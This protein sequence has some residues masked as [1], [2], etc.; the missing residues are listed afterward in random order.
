M[1]KAR[2]P[3]RGSMQFW[4]RKRARHLL[5]RVR[6]WATK[7]DTKPLGFIGYKAGMTHLH[8]NDNRAKSTTAGEKIF[9]P[10][11]I[12][13]CP[14]ITVAGA[15]FYKQTADGWKKVSHVLAEKQDKYLSRLVSIPKSQKK[16]ID[17][18]TEFDDV[19]LIIHSNPSKTSI[20]TKKPRLIEV[21]MG[22][23]KDEKFAYAKENLGK[24][25][26]IADVF[27]QGNY[28]DV[29]GISKGKGFQG[30]VK[31]YGVPIRQHKSE[32]VKRGIGNLGAWTPKRVD[33][34]VPQAGKMGYHLRTEYNKQ[35]IKIGQDGKDVNRVG[36]ITKYGEI[37]TSYLLVKGS[38][39]G[40]RKRAVL[41]TQAI[42]QDPKAVK[43]APEVV[44]IAR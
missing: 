37:K 8:I 25:V 4:P 11:T 1:S 13:E 28:V 31:R 29:H 30:T 33:Y 44:Y 10:A 21:A 5:A 3:R 41:L 18:I 6:S 35:V 39:I 23:S 17:E 26:A 36:G 20:G 15:S 24:E 32:K 34:R 43:G 2:H 16:K 38:V 22:G 40:P 19:R 14:P 9:M 27:D 12:I 7:K 42:R